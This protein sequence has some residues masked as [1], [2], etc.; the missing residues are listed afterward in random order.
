[1]RTRAQT[2]DMR[3]C[4]EQTDR[5]VNLANDILRQQRELLAE[6]RR[7]VTSGGYHSG[8]ESHDDEDEGDGGG[9]GTAAN[10]NS[11]AN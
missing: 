8:D 5:V 9:D 4:V 10:G 7:I 1:M 3:N 6:V 2:E 11:A